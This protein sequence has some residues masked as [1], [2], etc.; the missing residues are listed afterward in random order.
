MGRT[1]SVVEHPIQVTLVGLQ[2]SGETLIFIMNIYQVTQPIRH[3]PRGS[4]AVSADPNSPPTV[5]NRMVTGVFLPFW[6]REA[7]EMSEMSWVA[8]K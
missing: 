2:F 3:L 7:Q 8:S 5:E 6:K 4:R 1:G